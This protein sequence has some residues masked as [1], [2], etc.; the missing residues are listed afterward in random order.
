LCRTLAA[1]VLLTACSGTDRVAGPDGT[2]PDDWGTFQ[3]ALAA[4][5]PALVCGA[6][7]T[8]DLLADGTT[9]AGT[10]TAANDDASLYV[11]FETTDPWWIGRSAVAATASASEIPRNGAGNPVIGKFPYKQKHRDAPHS[12]TWEIPLSDV[13]GPQAV[14]AAFAE[15]GEDAEGA[16][17]D[18][19]PFDDSGSWATYF[20]HDVQE[21]EGTVV[22]TDG[23]TVEFD[24][25]LELVIPSGSLEDPAL[26]TVADV[27]SAPSPF[28]A[29]AVF[30]FG[31]DGLGFDPPATGTLRYDPSALPADVPEE[32]IR[33][34]ALVDGLLEFL[35]VVAR[36][37]EANS[38]SFDVSHFSVYGLAYPGVDLAVESLHVDPNP[39]R[40][41]DEILVVLNVENTG[42]ASTS[43]DAKALIALS[44]V[45]V[46]QE[47]LP[48]SCEP[49]T[50]IG[51]N[52]E[53][54]IPCD[55]GVIGPGETASF[56]LLLK[57]LIVPG[58]LEPKTLHIQ[59]EVFPDPSTGFA[60]IEPS[61]DGAIVDL[62][63]LP[64]VSADLRMKAF[65]PGT[66]AQ[67]GLE[68][69]ISATLESLAESVDPVDA[70]I[71]FEFPDAGSTGIEVVTGQLP[72][73]CTWGQSSSSTTI[74]CP[75]GTLAPGEEATR[76]VVV[77]PLQVKVYSVSATGLPLAGDPTPDNN[78]QGGSW[79]S[80]A[81]V[82]DIDASITRPLA[83]IGVGE[84]TTFS[85]RA[86]NLG[87][88]RLP[89]GTLRIE[90]EGEADLVTGDADCDV[91]A[92]SNRSAALNC[93]LP[94]LASGES[95]PNF[96][97]TVRATTA[98]I[99]L[100]GHAI[101]LLP[102]YVDDTNAAND[103]DQAVVT[104]RP[105]NLVD[106]AVEQLQE[107]A[108]PVK[109][110][111]EVTYSA[112]ATLLSAA[113]TPVTGGSYVLR[114]E[115]DVDFV[116]QGDPGCGTSSLTVGEG[117]EMTC[118]L[119]SYVASEVKTFSLTVSPPT[120]PQ[121]LAVSASV[122]PGAGY[123]ETDPSNN[124]LTTST[125]VEPL[126]ADLLMSLLLDDPDPVEAGNVVR[127]E[128][129]A[130]SATGSDDVPDAVVRFL[131]DGDA[132]LVNLP[133]GVG[134]SC[135]SVDTSSAD[136][137][138]LCTIETLRS[139]DPKRFIYDVRALSGPTLDAEVEI[140]AD[141]ETTTDTDGT[142][143]RQTQQTTVSTGSSSYSGRVVFSS[144]RDGQPD[145]YVKDL[146]TG[147]VTRLTNDGVAEYGPTWS[148][149]GTRIAFRRES[150][151]FL[152]SFDIWMIDSDGSGLTRLT[153]TGDA[154]TPN[155]SPD[156]TEIVYNDSNDGDWEIYVLQVAS[157]STI[158]KLTDDTN[159]DLA[160]DW[161]P[162]GTTIV[163]RE[164]P[165]FSDDRFWTMS[166]VDGSGLTFLPFADG[167]LGSPVWS[168]DGSRIAY[169][170]Q[171]ASTG[172]ANV[173][174]FDLVTGTRTVVEADGT[175]NRA[176]S[177]SPDGAHLVFQKNELNP[178][179]FNDD[180]DL[181]IVP[182]DGSSASELV[183]SSAEDESGP[184]WN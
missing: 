44:G 7:T 177:W 45:F 34:A 69:S 58:T 56:E 35:P 72:T 124:E 142:N 144:D 131:L 175:S 127:Y 163:F 88:D 132:E 55:V 181:W 155:W 49:D 13:D 102:D 74:S 16:W 3:P 22:G 94:Q 103:T 4:G 60:D 67:A 145:L 182:S 134:F 123:E 108:D 30:D 32:E 78:D 107:S 109:P 68:R 84:T 105:D 157:P 8:V 110:G 111:Q 97:L 24:D 100:T 143:N 15:L 112:Q 11:T 141:S 18:G 5:P 171:V 162:D 39:A 117:V 54:E 66:T 179:L 165:Q 90:V 138:V 82:A 41:V 73:G 19:R 9:L 137:A 31:P 93:P 47:S 119:G 48:E 2:E 36:D 174:V 38:V 50:E 37:L 51:R 33:P 87:G 122:V 164:A 25:R 77:R 113:T 91:I 21:C 75:V 10:V 43:V 160:P 29:G 173:E 118:P 26:I 104:V 20:T 106:F 53:T 81:T 148:P 65:G 70:T 156:G 158:R 166:A 27:P 167:G 126:S 161:S 61:N 172:E 101:L 89:A 23:G 96:E 12:V 76:A 40:Y 170:I 129:F 28:L 86:K 125:S 149:D 152:N 169:S 184:D 128:A 63:V 99:D 139:V 80:T 176:P 83:E 133:T 14:I 116:S 151:T 1:A 146:A 121:S 46:F 168:P 6:A 135:E 115:G 98:G 120:A 59:A 178:D 180:Y 64:D 17:A 92:V 154:G 159:Q 183:E 57:P 140:F 71:V 42:A 62:P 130:R 79:Q 147:G 52:G 136:V 150:E 95:S 85:A 153:T 114:V